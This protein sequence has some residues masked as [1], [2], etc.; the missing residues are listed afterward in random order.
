MSTPRGRLASLTDL[1]VALLPRIELHGRIV[2]RHMRCA[3]QRQEAVAEMTALVWKW[4]VS[5]QERGKDPAGF[6]RALI[7]FAARAVKSGRR[8]C[9]T[10][11][12]RDV[13]S[14]RAQRGRGFTVA[15]LPLGSSLNGTVYEEALQHNTQTPVDEQVCFRLDFPA[16]L[17]TRTDRDRRVIQDLMRGER[18]L[19]VSRRYGTTPARV[20]QLRREFQIDWSRFCGD[21]DEGRLLL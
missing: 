5:L 8:L 12:A 6:P 3:H 9:G 21:R 13:L 17:L 11:K 19:D 14:P 7:T 18:T 10:E 4:C 15:P 2:F 1:F 16:W 20:S